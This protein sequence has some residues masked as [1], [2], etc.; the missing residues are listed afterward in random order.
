[1]NVGRAGPGV[2]AK[3]TRISTSMLQRRL[4]I[5]YPRAARLM[6]MLEA[7]QVVG[8]EEGLGSREVLVADDGDEN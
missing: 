7:E 6:D 2:A 5:G 3:H 8:A 1:M 4:R